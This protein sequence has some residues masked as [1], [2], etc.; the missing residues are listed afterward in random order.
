MQK[1]DQKFAKQIFTL[2]KKSGIEACE[3]HFDLSKH[4]IRYILRRYSFIPSAN[5]RTF[6][7]HEFILIQKPEIAYILGL[8]W[9]DGHIEYPYRITIN[10]V[11]EDLI[12]LKKV[13]QSTSSHWTFRE[14]KTKWRD[15]LCVRLCNKNLCQ[16][17]VN[18]GYKAK[19]SETACKILS[20]IPSHLHSYFF[21]G[22]IDGDGHFQNSPKTQY[23][24]G[25][26]CCSCSSTYDQDWTY[27]EKLL[28]R[29]KINYK[30]SRIKRIMKKGHSNASSSIEF[31][32]NADIIKFGNYIYSNYIQ[33][34]IG[35]KRKYDK[36]QEIVSYTNR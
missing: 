14:N 26:R 25:K 31:Y 23:S 22:L 20:K 34:G 2:Y 15:I 24:S 21:R 19:S 5:H 3:K 4:K 28:K 6:D 12:T 7:I 27:F 29:L 8:I 1:Y 36:F 17:L 18:Q 32:K 16:F 30:I 9:A 11:K 10:G 35:L 33:D 13:F